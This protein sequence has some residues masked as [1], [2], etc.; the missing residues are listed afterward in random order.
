MT[1]YIER[2]MASNKLYDVYE[3]VKRNIIADGKPVD[4]SLVKNIMLRFEKALNAV[5]NVDVAPVRH[6][7]W[8]DEHKCT[9]CHNEA[10]YKISNI[11]PDYDYDWEENLVE[12]GDYIWDIEWVET[13]YC[14]NCGAK[15]DG[16]RL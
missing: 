16:D 3:Y 12:T 10:F 13:A 9:V 11:R 7:R 15:M 5:P 14:P 8:D 4:A 2:R 1:E 6:G